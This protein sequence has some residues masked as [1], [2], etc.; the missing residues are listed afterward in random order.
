MLPSGNHWNL[1][2][3][4]ILN[5]LTSK[6]TLSFFFTFH[7]QQKNRIKFTI[8][9]WRMGTLVKIQEYDTRWSLRFILEIPP[10]NLGNSWNL[11]IRVFHRECFFGPTGEVDWPPMKNRRSMKEQQASI[12]VPRSIAPPLSSCSKKIPL[13]QEEEKSRHVR[14]LSSA[15]VYTLNLFKDVPKL[16]AAR[17]KKPVGPKTLFRSRR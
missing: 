16:V 4:I 12:T 1:C 13:A 10:S 11:E 2:K 8:E 3:K 9:I 15:G 7:I 17:V 14:E 5:E 6:V